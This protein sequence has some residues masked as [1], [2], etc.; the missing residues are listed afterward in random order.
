MG[1]LFFSI[2]TVVKAESPCVTSIMRCPD[3]SQHYVVV[4]EGK[5]I[6]AWACIICDYCPED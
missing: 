1:V 6:V 4:C 5:D 3:G 2:P